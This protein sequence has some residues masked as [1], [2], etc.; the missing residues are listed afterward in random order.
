MCGQTQSEGVFLI[1]FQFLA[2]SVSY[3][4]SLPHRLRTTLCKSNE[5]ACAPS[6]LSLST[7]G[8]FACFLECHS[9]SLV[10][11]RLVLFSVQLS[12]PSC[13]LA[14]WLKARS[15]RSFSDHPLHVPFFRTLAV[16]CVQNVGTFL[17][18][19][20]EAVGACQNFRH[21]LDCFPVLDDPSS[22][23]RP[24][25][26][27]RSSGCTFLRWHNRSCCIRHLEVHSNLAAICSLKLDQN[28]PFKCRM[29]NFASKSKQEN[30]NQQSGAR[31]FELW[32][33]WN[34]ACAGH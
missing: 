10:Q 6:V 9:V 23:V 8:G 24:E 5:S 16:S 33:E 20:V 11:V 19:D 28:P 13:S 27:H 34:C 26:R 32:R 21:V 7:R 22:A 25:D 4:S 15:S 1:E 3:D 12:F 30:W 31:Q 2:V 29:R 18:D 14:A 17:L